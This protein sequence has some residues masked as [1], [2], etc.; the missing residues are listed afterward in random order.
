MRVDGDSGVD[1][2]GVPQDDVGGFSSYAA[3]LQKLSHC[4]RDMAF[5]AI[6]D[7]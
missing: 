3:K 6:L 2:E 1:P 7:F 5:E 4:S